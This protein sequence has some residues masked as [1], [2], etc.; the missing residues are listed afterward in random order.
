MEECLELLSSEQECPTDEIFAHQVRLHLI[1][2]NTIQ[3]TSN[4]TGSDTWDAPRASLPFYLKALRSQLVSAKGSLS[5][6][7]QNNSKTLVSQS[8]KCSILILTR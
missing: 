4:E 3:A 6:E 8:K 5:V 7:A 1:A 2:A